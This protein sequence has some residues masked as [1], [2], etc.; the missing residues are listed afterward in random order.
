M[1]RLPVCLLLLLGSWQELLARSY[2]EVPELSSIFQREGLPGTFVLLDA[3]SDTVF[4][5]NKARA[6][7]RFIPA[8]TFKIANSLIGLDT[9]AVKSVDEVLPYGG[10]PQRFKAWEH[11]MNLRDAIK[12]SNVAIYQEV[13]RR[14]GLQRMRAGVRKLGYGNME[15]G[16]VVDRFWLEGPLAISAVEQTEFL[17]R[18][19]EE[20]LPVRAEAMRAV[21]EITLLEK[22][23]IYELHG[24]TG[25]F[26]DSK[27]QI[28]WWVG[29]VERDG[30]VYP[31]A[32][33]IDMTKDE[34][35]AK[36]IPIG[37]ECLKALGKL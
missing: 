13:A 28:G 33:N 29:W 35:A 20:K 23:R 27:Q 4:V 36:R 10:K 26:F 37:S 19:I 24:K 18:L 11:D 31:F 17:N 32:L 1:R 25:W 15:I 14:I 6:E 21:K 7:Q 30:K 2:Q 3:S 5:S 8:S 12:A 9:G 22:T 16:N 34:D